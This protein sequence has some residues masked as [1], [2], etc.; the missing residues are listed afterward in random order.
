MVQ[1]TRKCS[2]DG[3]EKRYYSRGYCRP[4]YERWKKNG[5]PEMVRVP[6]YDCSIEGCPNPHAARGW[7]SKHWQR[8]RYQGDPN[9]T[10]IVH[11]SSVEESFAIRTKQQGDCVVWTGNKDPRGYGLVYV[12]GANRSVHRFVWERE[13]GPIPDGYQIDHICHNTACFKIDHLRIATPKENSFNRKGAYSNSR[14]GVRNVSP[15]GKKWQVRIRKDNVLHYFGSYETLE[16]AAEVAS[17]KR[18][19]LF[20]DFAGRG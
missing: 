13:K 17:Q 1:A 11:T 2:Y 7:C 9:K 10:L 12:N 15:H 5:S 19:E 16:E 20:G 18:K 4:H 14:S 6:R 3:C 8:W